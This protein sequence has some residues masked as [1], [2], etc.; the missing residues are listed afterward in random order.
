ML[1]RQA[2]VDPSNTGAFMQIRTAQGLIELRRVDPHGVEVIFNGVAYGI[3]APHLAIIGRFF[4]A[5]GIAL[6]QDINAGWDGPQHSQEEGF[7]P[8]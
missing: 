7:S 4:L 6:G 5:A 2:W 3:T 1:A 8:L